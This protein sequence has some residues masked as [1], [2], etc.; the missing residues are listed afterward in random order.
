MIQDVHD[1]VNMTCLAATQF[2]P[3]NLFLPFP[4]IWF[5]LG[6][7]LV[8]CIRKSAK[9]GRTE[10]WS[11]FKYFFIKLQCFSKSVFQ[12]TCAPTLWRL[13]PAAQEARVVLDYLTRLLAQQRKTFD[14]ANTLKSQKLAKKKKGGGTKNDLTKYSEILWQR[15][16]VS[17][18]KLF[19]WVNCLLPPHLVP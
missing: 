14:Y 7:H 17:I 15:I 2:F 18:V 13:M 12:C 10:M 19:P 11:T 9:V 8:A 6:F 5:I 4:L 3:W 16:S 1:T